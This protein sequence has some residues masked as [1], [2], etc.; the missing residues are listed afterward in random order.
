MSEQSSLINKFTDSDT[1][2]A[3]SQALAEYG[4][5]AIHKLS[6]AARDERRTV[7]DG[8]IT[9][10]GFCKDKR[11]IEVLQELFA[12]WLDERQK[13]GKS[14]CELSTKIIE[15]YRPSL[16]LNVS[17]EQQNELLKQRSSETLDLKQRVNSYFGFG[18]WWQGRNIAQ[19]VARIAEKSL[20]QDD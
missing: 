15:N 20:R 16:F 18:D 11:A 14:L 19:A 6:E 4:R 1:S 9:A 5:P 13:T 12:E 17:S 3:A 8:A 7:R 2:I 10:L